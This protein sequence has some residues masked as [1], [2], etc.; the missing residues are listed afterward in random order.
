MPRFKEMPMEPDQLILIPK[1]LEET[2]PKDSDVRVFKDIMQ[3]LDCSDILPK[4]ADTGCP[5]YPPFV[6]LCVIVY[7]YS[8]GVFS[9]RK[10]EECLKVDIRFMYLAGGL[11]PDHNTISRF[12]KANNETIEMLFKKTVRLSMELGLVLLKSISI[13]GSKILA[14]ASKKSIYNKER[15][16]KELQKVEEILAKA[17]QIDSEEDHI[18][19]KGKNGNEKLPDADAVKEKLEKLANELENNSCTNVVSTDLDSR[20][21][22]TRNH[23]KAPAYNLQVAVDS[24]NQIM[25]AIKLTN[26]ETDT[27][28]F[29]EMLEHVE[30]NTGFKPDLSLADSG[31]YDEKSLI[32][33]QESGHDVLMPVLENPKELKRTDL[34]ASKCFLH[35]RERDVYI[36]PAGKEL[37]YQKIHK[38]TSSTY[39]QYV[40]SECRDCSFRSECFS[41]NQANKCIN[42]SVIDHIRSNMRERLQSPEG[43]AQY[44][45]RQQTV[46]PVFGQMKRN[47]MFMRLKLNGTR[48]ASVQ[49]ALMCIVHNITKCM[50]SAHVREYLAKMQL[51]MRYIC[52]FFIGR[53]LFRTKLLLQHSF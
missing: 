41:A 5:A 32:W 42:V 47:R 2:L 4:G 39:R 12:L 10:I 40:A 8:K 49:T 23:G 24:E 18:Y 33:A 17:Q 6:M 48:G 21:M 53:L 19:G 20:V 11:R 34:F 35:D 45:L 3:H 14:N 36:C 30:D 15:L 52:A 13:D 16:D 29:P 50:T 46:E 37:K 38:S 28:F 7:A 27:G 51:K 9:S 44:R 1:S 25:L 22:K 31:Y 26:R 43:K